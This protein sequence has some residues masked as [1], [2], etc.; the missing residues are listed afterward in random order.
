M[1]QIIHNNFTFTVLD[2]IQVQY[3]ELVDLVIHS[4]SI[5]NNEKQYWF[6]ILPSMT[7]EQMCIRDSHSDRY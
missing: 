4:E 6:D 1:A 5:D 7:D 2:E 3:S